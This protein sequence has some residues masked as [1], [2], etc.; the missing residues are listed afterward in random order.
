MNYFEGIRKN[1][2]RLQRNRE[3]DERGAAMVEYALLLSGVAAVVVVAVNT[4]G[5]R[6]LAAFGNFGI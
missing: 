6:L 5:E 1:L 4:F 2:V 3:N